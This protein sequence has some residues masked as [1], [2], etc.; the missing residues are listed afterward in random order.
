MLLTLNFVLLIL[1][2]FENNIKKMPSELVHEYPISISEKE[3]QQHLNKIMAGKTPANTTG[4]V[5]VPRKEKK[6]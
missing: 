4:I 6:K 5:P 2:K 3:L 1:I